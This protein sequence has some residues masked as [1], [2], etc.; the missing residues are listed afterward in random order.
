[1]ANVSGVTFWSEPFSRFCS[2][3]GEISRA[4]SFQG[5]AIYPTSRFIPQA[6]SEFGVRQQ[7]YRCRIVCLDKNVDTVAY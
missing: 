4:R 6:G 3:P 1:M 2:R 7:H 5:D